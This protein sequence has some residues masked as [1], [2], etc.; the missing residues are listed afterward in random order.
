MSISDVV[1]FVALFSFAVV[2]LPLLFVVIE[3][4]CRQ[5]EWGKKDGE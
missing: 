5:R 4:E 3:D 2:V 1:I